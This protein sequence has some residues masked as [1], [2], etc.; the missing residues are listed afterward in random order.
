MAAS[1]SSAAPADWVALVDELRARGAVKASWGEFA[2]E[3]A[4]P[5]QTA[6]ELEREQSRALPLNQDERDELAALRDFKARRAEF[7]DYD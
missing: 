3:F 6:A 2:V 7:G 5:Q 4:V 1:T